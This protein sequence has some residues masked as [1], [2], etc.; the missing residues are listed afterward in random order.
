MMGLRMNNQGGIIISFPKREFEMR[1]G[2]FLCM[3]AALMVIAGCASSKKINEITL[4]MSRDQVITQ[5]GAPNSTS[6]KDNIEYLNYKLATDGLFRDDYFVRLVDGQVD[7]YGR[8]GD[9]GMGY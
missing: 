7:A 3:M 9:F 8:A 2:R 5:M 4:G 6:A 1:M